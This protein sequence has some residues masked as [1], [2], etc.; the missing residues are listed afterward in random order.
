M[1]QTRHH[2][3]PPPP[4]SCPGRCPVVHLP[5]S[6]PVGTLQ[7]T[8]HPLCSVLHSEGRSPLQRKSLVLQHNARHSL[9]SLPSVALVEEGCHSCPQWNL[10][11][12][13]LHRQRCHCLIRWQWFLWFPLK[14]LLRRWYYSVHVVLLTPC[15]SPGGDCC[16]HGGCC[17][18]G[19]CCRHGECCHHGGPHLLGSHLEWHSYGCG[20]FPLTRRT[21]SDR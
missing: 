19:D 12:G 8:A 20:G 3:P 18:H 11:H 9:S 10:H 7:H 4:P 15:C 1:T 16:N 17:R 2:S 14:H 5:Q 6:P 21:V 13:W